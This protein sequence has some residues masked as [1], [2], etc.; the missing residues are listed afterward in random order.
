MQS[1]RADCAACCGGQVNSKAPI[2]VRIKAWGARRSTSTLGFTTNGSTSGPVDRANVL[3]EG[4]KGHLSVSFL[5]LFLLLPPVFFTVV[6]REERCG[7]PVLLWLRGDDA[8]GQA[9]S[10]AARSR[11]G[12]FPEEGVMGMAGNG[13]SKCSARAGY[14][15][16]GDG[17]GQSEGGAPVR[18][19]EWWRPWPHMARREREEEELE[20]EL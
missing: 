17:D 5:F 12:W 20:I 13:E 7:A 2:I 3:I 4:V 9:C 1:S 6:L 18:E 16:N 8:G 15:G 10:R 19:I 11:G 14:G